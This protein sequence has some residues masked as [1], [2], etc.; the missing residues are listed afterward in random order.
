MPKDQKTH[1]YSYQTGACVC[2][3]AR[4]YVPARA[5]AHSGKVT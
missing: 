2:V 3:R 4:E 5:H 1:R